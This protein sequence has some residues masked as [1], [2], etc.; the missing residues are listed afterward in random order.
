MKFIPQQ[1]PR[2][3][4]LHDQRT[5]GRVVD[6]ENEAQKSETNVAPQF[7]VLIVDRD[8]MSS[9]LLAT[10]ICHET[11]IRASA[12]QAAD[13]L[14]CLDVERVDMVIIGG[15]VDQ[16]PPNEFDLA[17]A[18]SRARPN[19]LIVVLLNH[20]TRDSVL[21]AFRSGARGVFPRQR[22]IA[23]LLDCLE[24]VRNG[25]LWAAEQ[26]TTHLLDAIRSFP[27]PSPSIES[28]PLS[29][30]EKQVVQSAA[31]GKTNKVIAGE[32]GLSEHT[33]K[34]YLFRAFE[35]LGV[36]SRTELLFYLTQRGQTFGSPRAPREMESESEG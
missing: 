22:P 12:V 9:Q 2:R 23:D 5:P 8:S 27:T 35:K 10:A 11:N 4:D 17:Q 32:L 13:L 6:R 16:R 19:V 14:R 1:S 34:N 20:S 7:R 36:S 21:S 30:R 18:A 29:Y 31:R 25:Y 33:V 15:E 26:E 3:D 28:L 24:R